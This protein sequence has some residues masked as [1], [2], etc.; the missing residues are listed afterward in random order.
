MVDEE[1]ACADGH[2][3]PIEAFAEAV[4]RYAVEDGAVVVEDTNEP[5]D[6]TFALGT[7]TPTLQN[8]WCENGLT[9]P[10]VE[11]GAL[12]AALVA[13]ETVETAVQTGDGTAYRFRAIPDDDP[14]TG[15]LTLREQTDDTD[16]RPV[17]DHIASV[18][19][20]DLRNPLDVAKARARAAR[21][22][23]ETEHFDRLDR[24]HDRMER[25]IGDVL[26]L[27]RGSG[28]VDTT[29]GVSVETVA[30]DAWQAVETASASLAV[31]P[32]LPETE[33]D[34][35]R[36]QRLFENLFRNSVE[37]GSTSSRTQS[38]AAVND[39]S[40]GDWGGSDDVDRPT[41]GTTVRVDSTAGGFAVA[42]N[43]QAIPPGERDRIFEP[44]YTVSG[45]G[46]GLGLTIVDRIA[47][48]HGWTVTATESE[49][50]GARFEV[51]GLA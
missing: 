41:E 39:G 30:R 36:L 17:G 49:V 33:A 1:P 42:D 24:A 18:V 51:T 37:H 27:A 14:S 11:A 48:A 3:A 46:T 16:V 12:D 29:A 25:I 20:H 32:D 19:S 21:E 13:G 22:T 35:D 47:T 23:G 15:T 40:T 34:A 31:A 10:G 6:S 43:G 4:G 5:F 44:G 8:W 50:G 2:A 7:G 9:A 26:T 38:D 28:A 45:N